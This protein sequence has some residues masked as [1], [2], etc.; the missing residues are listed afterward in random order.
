MRDSGT[1]TVYVRFPGL[2]DTKRGQCKS[3]CHASSRSILVSK[4]TPRGYGSGSWAPRLVA[5]WAELSIE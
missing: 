3:T 1:E 5:E 4:F 2:Y